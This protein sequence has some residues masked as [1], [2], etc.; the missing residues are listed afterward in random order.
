MTT[1]TNPWTG[2]TGN[3]LPVDDVIDESN[4]GF[5]KLRHAL[6]GADSEQHPAAAASVS[7]AGYVAA[8]WPHV[9]AAIQADHDKLGLSFIAQERD[10]R[11]R[12]VNAEDMRQAF[13]ADPANL[14]DPD[15][16]RRRGAVLSSLAVMGQVLNA[17]VSSWAADFDGFQPRCPLDF[18]V[19]AAQYVSLRMLLPRR[20]ERDDAVDSN[21]PSLVMGGTATAL[22]MCWNLLDQIPRAYRE[23]TGE[24]PTRETVEQIWSESRELIYRIG[25]GSLAAFVSFASACSS[26]STAMLWD[27]AGDLGLTRRGDRFVWTMNTALR[28]RYKALLGQISGDQH[29]HYVGCAALFT[30]AAALPLATAWADSIESD[31]DPIVFAELLRWITAVAR[32][33]YFPAFTQAPNTP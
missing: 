33:Q 16:A 10:G 20:E 17:A 14:D 1:D 6:V 21:A 25:S 13:V 27:G 31:K 11:S 9:I 22:T 3:Y 29:G 18:D 28:S 19:E 8:F 30:R 26:Q 2:T 15:A 32:K 4:A 24:E 23:L 7:S 5:V 12:R